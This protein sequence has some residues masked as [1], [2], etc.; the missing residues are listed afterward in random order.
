[1]VEPKLIPVAS[2]GCAVRN[3]MNLCK[4][5]DR[6]RDGELDERQRHL[7][8]LHLPQCS[9]CR[10]SISILN[11]LVDSLNRCGHIFSPVQPQHIA[12]QASERT[13]SWDVQVIA[14]LR[15]VPAWTTVVLAL[16]VYAILGLFSPGQPKAQTGEYEVLTGE[17][18]SKGFGQ[19]QPQFQ[20]DDLVRW[21]EQ[22]GSRP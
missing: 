17:M 5:L 22:Q 4:L 18:E 15:P 11:N 10:L 6:Y 19:Q 16:A 9:Q 1:V 3:K 21:L 14:W 13:D 2:R 20:N 12:R 8:E 7:F